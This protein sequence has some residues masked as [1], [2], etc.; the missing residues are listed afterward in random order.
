MVGHQ[1]YKGKKLPTANEVVWINV[2][3]LSKD[4]SYLSVELLE[5]PCEGII[6]TKNLSS[7]ILY[8]NIKLH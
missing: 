3:D 1:F 7:N 5:Y 6:Q 2:G 8:F 4:L